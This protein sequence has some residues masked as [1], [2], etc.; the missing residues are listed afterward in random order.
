MKI[1][2]LRMRNLPNLNPIAISDLHLGDP[3]DP[4]NDCD[5]ETFE[6]FLKEIKPNPLFFV[7]DTFELWQFSEKKIVNANLPLLQLI[8][9][10]KPIFLLGNH[11]A[12]IGKRLK[13]IFGKHCFIRGALRL[14]TDHRTYLLYHGHQHD[15]WNSRWS[16][17]GYTISRF[18]GLL[19]R[20]IHQDIDIWAQQ[21]FRQG[22]YI[23]K[24]QYQKLLRQVARLGSREKVDIVVF[25]HTH[26]VWKGKKKI[27]LMNLGSWTIGGE[28][29][30]LDLRMG[31]LF[32]FS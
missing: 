23:T 26:Q 21:A 12:R 5:F 16:I 8:R 18:A 32:K 31:M 3:K 11:D 6:R 28:P 13:D 15:V 25:G 27:R 1:T 24:K 2:T 4:A 22:R 7:G 19:E 14:V 30:Y 17:L 10:H 29:M 20:I 9:T